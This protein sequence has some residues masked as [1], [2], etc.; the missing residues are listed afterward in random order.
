MSVPSRLIVTTPPWSARRLRGGPPVPFCRFLLQFRV[1]F[2]RI[3]HLPAEPLDVGIE[4]PGLRGLRPYP[5]GYR[6]AGQR[7]PDVVG[8]RSDHLVGL[9]ARSLVTQDPDP[10]VLPE[11]LVEIQLVASPPEERGRIERRKASVQ[12]G[13]DCLPRLLAHTSV[14]PVQRVPGANRLQ[15]SV[16]VI[17]T[18]TAH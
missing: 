7:H 11:A 2:E 4:F 8:K 13:G 15:I 1:A 9:V 16:R 17:H 18:E 5:R 10:V 14:S 3:P 6:A 12:Q